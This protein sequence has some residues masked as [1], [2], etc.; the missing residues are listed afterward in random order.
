[1]DEQG[2][3]RLK[4]ILFV[5]LGIIILLVGIYTIYYYRQK[6]QDAVRFANIS[7]IQAAMN[8]LYTDQASYALGAGCE[9]GSLLTDEACLT[10]LQQYITNLQILRDPV[11]TNL[12]CTVENCGQRPC[13]YTIGQA[14]TKDGY[15]IYF[16]LE[17]GFE[18]LASG[19]HYV[20]PSG[21]Y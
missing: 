16:H 2:K 1:M 10:T 12:L 14:P 4:L 8:R 6:A 21:V 11:D 9:V 15:Q 7:A 13:A 3:S 19:C 18:G 5:A 17:R 20:D